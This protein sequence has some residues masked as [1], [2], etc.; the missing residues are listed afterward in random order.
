MDFAMRYIYHIA[1]RLKKSV[2]FFLLESK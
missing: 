1:F 2:R